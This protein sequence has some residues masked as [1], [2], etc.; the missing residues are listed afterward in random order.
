MTV[1][2]SRD[3]ARVKAW[4]RLAAEPRERR[5]SGLA[6]IE[7][8]HLVET[9]LARGGVPKSLILSESAAAKAEIRQLLKQCSVEPFVLEDALFKRVSD[10]E[11]PTGI[12]AEFVIPDHRVD[13][14]ESTGCVFLEGIQDA[15]N[16]GTIL[17]SAAA[18]AIPDVIVGKGCADPWS[19]KALRAGMGGHFFLRISM[20]PDLVDEVK[21]FGRDSVCTSAHGGKAIGSVDLTGRIGWIFGSEGAGVSEPLSAVASHIATIPTPGGAESLNVAASAA[22]C[23]YERER[24]I[25]TRVAGP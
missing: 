24:Q 1:I 21:R 2:R 6:L 18:F 4:T 3:N 9:Y 17:R 15:G 25:S 14:K 13:A 10:A 7:G 22:I 12:A 19:P 5:E 8:V 11:T 16:V 20:S 23:L